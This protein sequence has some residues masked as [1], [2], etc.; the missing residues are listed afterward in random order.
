MTVNI[1]KC[2]AL[3]IINEG[4]RKYVESFA[5]SL[6]GGAIKALKWG[7]RYRYLGVEVGRRRTTS[8]QEV[9]HNTIL[10]RTRKAINVPEGGTLLIDQKVPWSGNQL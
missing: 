2:A 6:Q 4:Q 9:R 5:P 3:S 1:E 8:L 10:E 7:E